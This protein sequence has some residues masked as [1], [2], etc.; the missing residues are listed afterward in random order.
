MKYVFIVVV[1]ILV[2]I[3]TSL[4]PIY[5]RVTEM[6]TIGPSGH[7]LSS[8]WERVSLKTFFEKQKYAIRAWD[9]E[10][11]MNAYAMYPTN[12]LVW[13]TNTSMVT[14]LIIVLT[15]EARKKI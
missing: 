6:R 3:G 10:T 9:D 14:A 4:L 8:E 15:Q 12:V 13:L 7:E 11:R 1:F 5:G 2:G